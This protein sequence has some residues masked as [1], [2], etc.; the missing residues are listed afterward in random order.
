MER[1][2]LNV[3]PLHR[4]SPTDPLPFTLDLNTTVALTTLPIAKLHSTGRLFVVD[5]SYQLAYT[6]S[7]RFGAACTALFFIHPISGDFL[8]LA[9]KTNVGSDLVYTPLDNPNDWL[10]AKIM[11][12]SND[13]F[14]AQMFHLVASHDVAE[15]AHQAAMRTLSDEHPIMVLLERRT[16]PPFSL[17]STFTDLGLQLCSKPTPSDRK[18]TPLH[19]P[20]NFRDPH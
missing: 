1:L 17:W 7:P 10:L 11:F 12:N 18:A 14:H 4:L 5:H 16:I 6:K 20:S 15:I 3:Y 8:P 19:N 9:I 2:S 13:L